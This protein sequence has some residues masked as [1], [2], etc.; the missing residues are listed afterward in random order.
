MRRLPLAIDEIAKLVVVAWLV[1]A[2][3]VVS[4][5][6]NAMSVEVAPFGNG[7]VNGS[8]AVVR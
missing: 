6:L 2:L 7:Y 3:V 1:V 5:P 4:P 8:V